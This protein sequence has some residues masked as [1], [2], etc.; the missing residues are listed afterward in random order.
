M[1]SQRARFFSI[2]TGE[3][4]A[5]MPFFPDITDWYLDRRTPPGE[6]RQFSPG[7]F[8][9][10]AADI[11]KNPGSMP[12]KYRDFPLFDFY[13]QFDWGFHVH[14]YHWYRTIFSGGVETESWVDGQKRYYRVITPLGEMTRMDMLASDGTWSRKEFFI[15]EMRDLKTMRY[16]VEHTHFEPEFEK[17]DAI[18]QE[19]GD[20]GQG[21]IVLS[22]SPFGKLVHEYMGFEQVIYTLNDD[23]EPLFEFME[24]QERKDLELVALAA[25]APERLVIMS[26]H[27]DEIL[28]SPSQWRDYCVPFYRKITDILHG[29]DKFV[30]THL[31]GNFKGYF[32]ILDQPGF[33][34][35]DGCTPAPMFNFEVEE[36]ADA[37]PDGMYAFC[38]IPATLFCQNLLTEE[39]LQFADRI[40]TALKGR[41]VLNVGDILPPNGDIEQVIALGEYAKSSWS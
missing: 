30:S 13:R 31:D 25:R 23:P 39:I 27:T 20:W 4:P 40:L 11:H 24:I 2:L 19:L 14:L 33:D 21:D 28:I 10:D 41:A 38:G 22:R 6:P 8:I 5:N 17:I 26:D 16:M 29:A 9:P 32:D 15:K 36:L 1:T 12:E 35:L 37:L 18:R 34:L 7:E 3:K